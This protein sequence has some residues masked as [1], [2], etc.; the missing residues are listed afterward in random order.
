MLT[1]RFFFPVIILLVLPVTVYAQAMSVIGGKG[2]AHECYINAK[3]ATQ[4][5]YGGATH[6][7]IEPCDYALDHVRLNK[8]DLAA[9]YVNR[10]VLRVALE[11][12]NA[13]FADY[14]RGMQLYPE[15]GEIYVNRGNLYY[16]GRNYEMAISDY[17][18]GISLQIEQMHIVHLNR[19]MAYEH[20]DA[21]VNAMEDYQLSLEY[22]PDWSIAQARLLKLQAKMEENNNE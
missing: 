1:S 11:E 14:E 6:R 20:V 13:A 17:S 10:G 9:T 18:M 16:L 15:V 12:Y 5:D 22:L 21:N 3:L 19:G 7:S 2:K 4:L 8:R